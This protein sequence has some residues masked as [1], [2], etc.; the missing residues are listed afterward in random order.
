MEKLLRAQKAP[1]I[2]GD[3]DEKICERL[4]MVEDDKE[5]AEEE[6]GSYVL[7][8]GSIL[9]L[10]FNFIKYKFFNSIYYN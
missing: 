2:F 7:I 3:G 5:E 1:P 4:K 8:F 10:A 6:Q 9:N